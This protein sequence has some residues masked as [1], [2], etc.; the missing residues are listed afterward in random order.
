MI[1]FKL[2]TMATTL[3]LIYQPLQGDLTARAREVLEKRANDHPIVIHDPALLLEI[4]R[5]NHAEVE[6]NLMVNYQTDDLEDG[7]SWGRD[8]SPELRAMLTPTKAE[9]PVK[10]PNRLHIWDT[11]AYETL[12]AP[13]HPDGCDHGKGAYIA[14]AKFRDT[15]EGKLKV[16]EIDVYIFDVVG[17]QEAC[18]R[19]GKEPNEYITP[20]TVIDLLIA[21]AGPNASPTYK[22]AA[23]IIDEATQIVANKI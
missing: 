3:H 7:V 22:V 11:P 13:F 8:L 4:E 10:V 18:I 23:H 15:E 17:V 20:G 1:R 9:E 19:F 2:E 16:A 14:S 21:A 12:R 6:C 5:L